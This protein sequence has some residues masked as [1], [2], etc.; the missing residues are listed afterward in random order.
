MTKKKSNNICLI[1]FSLF[2]WLIAIS[3]FICVFVNKGK[4]FF[5]DMSVNDF[6]YTLYISG[7]VSFVICLALILISVFG[8]KGDF[9]K[10]YALRFLALLIALCC[11][12]I[13]TIVVSFSN[14]GDMIDF[15]PTIILVFASSVFVVSFLI[16]I[17]SFI[18]VI[19]GASEHQGSND[20][21]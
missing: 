15:R 16:I 4:T 8:F 17:A 5:I 7:N 2:N 14:P 6:F 3:T 11:A 20:K 19:V 12:Y 13:K 9:I 21:N 10:K 1:T 18:D